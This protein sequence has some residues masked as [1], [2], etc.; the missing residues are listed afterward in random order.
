MIPYCNAHGIGLIPWA[1]LAAGDL[2]HPLGTSTTRSEAKK[3]SPSWHKHSEADNTI[4]QRVE[5]IAQKRGWAMSQ[6]ALAW[7]YRKVSS[8]IVG[9]SSVRQLSV[10]HSICSLS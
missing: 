1:P 9:V 2:T 5:E 7:V 6:V 4:I 8:P 10:E 3:S